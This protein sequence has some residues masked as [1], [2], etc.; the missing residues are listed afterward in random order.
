LGL[1]LGLSGLLLVSLEVRYG[2]QHSED[3][4]QYRHNPPSAVPYLQIYL[5]WRDIKLH[6][7]SHI[8]KCPTFA[9]CQHLRLNSLSNEQ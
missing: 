8:R 9:G 6:A 5:V 7:K 3:K 2:S 1:K 4:R